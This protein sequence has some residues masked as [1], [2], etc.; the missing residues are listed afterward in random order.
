MNKKE[1]RN[2]ALIK[3]SLI[4]EALTKATHDLEFAS[5]DLR[6]ALGLSSAVESLVLLPIILE[7]N[8]AREAVRAFSFAK[9]SA[10]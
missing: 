2:E 4:K 6:E 8:K 3:E 9:N 1:L 10:T 7:V 5:N